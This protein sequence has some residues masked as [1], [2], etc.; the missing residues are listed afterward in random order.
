MLGVATGLTYDIHTPN[1]PKVILAR[2]EREII[3]KAG[4][5]GENKLKRATADTIQVWPQKEK[6][7]QQCISYPGEM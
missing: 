3:I 6:M 2:H 7:Q 5:A 4:G 1:T